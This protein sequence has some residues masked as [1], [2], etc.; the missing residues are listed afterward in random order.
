MRE[1]NVNNGLEITI[2]EETFAE[3]SNG[4]GEDDE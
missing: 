4:K 1:P 3:L 2:G